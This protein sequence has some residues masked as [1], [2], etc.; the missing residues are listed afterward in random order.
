MTLM[1]TLLI[2]ALGGTVGGRRATLGRPWSDNLRNRPGAHVAPH[3]IMLASRNNNV[4]VDGGVLGRAPGVRGIVPG[5]PLQEHERAALG[6]GLALA[7]G[8]AVHSINVSDNGRYFV[9]Q[10]GRPVF[11]LG[12]TQWNI[13]RDYSFEDARL[14]LE[15]SRSTGFAFVQAMLLGVGD[16]TKP[17]V[18]GEKPL[19]GDDPLTPNEAYFRNVDA[20]VDV[21]RKK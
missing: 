4:V 11:W 12:T 3:A 2:S 13:F 7:R 18:Y 15:R 17:N 20:V 10:R 16:G 14:I 5:E 9:D 8:E 6:R 21:A 19:T 1:C